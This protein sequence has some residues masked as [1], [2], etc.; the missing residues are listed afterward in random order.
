MCCKT[1]EELIEGM[2][3]GSIEDFHTF[4]E[5][6]ISFTY[7]IVYSLLKSREEAA[8]VC[9]DLFLEFY[10]KAHSYQPEKGSVKSWIAVKAKS[11]TID[12]IRK[13]KRTVLKDRIIFNREPSFD[14]VEE[15]AV[16][17][18]EASRLKEMM[19]QLPE[20]QQEAIFY[21]FF[22]S[23][24]HQ[25]IADKLGRPLGTVKSWIRYGLQNLKRAYLNDTSNKRRGKH[26]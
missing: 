7:K 20:K 10:T 1:D 4:Y 21:N 3:N 12:Y 9:H 17:Q 14:S 19:K 26:E 15:S 23:M 11:R 22:Q 24:T 18:I 25:E 8:D 6:Y 2:A 13:S 5:R 16:T